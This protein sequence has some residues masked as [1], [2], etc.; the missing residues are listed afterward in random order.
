M[1]VR[2]GDD[3]ATIDITG[4]TSPDSRIVAGKFLLCVGT[5]EVRKNVGLLYMAYREAALKGIDLPRMV[6]VGRAGWLTG[7]VLYQIATDPVVKDKFVVLQGINDQHL[8]WLFENC[9]YTVFPSVYE[10]WGLPI[11]ESLGY[12]K[13]CIASGTSSMTE[14]AGDLLEY[15]SPYNT[16]ELLDIMVKYLDDKVLHAKERE[17]ASKYK[18]HSWD[19]TYAQ[20]DK[21]IQRLPRQ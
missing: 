6:V 20:F 3:G 11:A 10:G 17:I 14:M 5:I 16:Q 13:M 15:H 9:R 18:Q 19:D 1:V 2:N 7:D 21:F 12:G 8:R 4:I